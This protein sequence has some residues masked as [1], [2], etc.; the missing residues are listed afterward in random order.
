MVRCRVEEP[1]VGI[2]EPGE[3]L[4]R[5]LPGDREPVLIVAGLVQGEQPLAE[6]R[7]ILEDALATRPAVL[8]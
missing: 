5:E 6:D 7:V 2:D 1:A 4:V 3:D 8:P